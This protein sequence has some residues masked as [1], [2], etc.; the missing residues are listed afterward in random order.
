[1]RETLEDIGASGLAATQ[2][3]VDQRVVV[4]V[5]ARRGFLPARASSRCRGR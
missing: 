1:M 5:L 4:Y 2:V 3:F